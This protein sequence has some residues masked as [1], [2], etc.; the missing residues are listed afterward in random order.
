VR[1][2]SVAGSRRIQTL[3]IHQNRG[4]RL[5]TVL[6]AIRNIHVNVD[7]AGGQPV[8]DPRRRHVERSDRQAL[9]FPDLSGQQIPGNLIRWHGG[10]EP[11]RADPPKI[12]VVIVG[13]RRD[14]FPVGTPQNYRIVYGCR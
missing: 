8:G 13:D 2:D 11:R 6:G 7:G 4:G 14:W 9:E 3:H 12:H 5:T 1:F 10:G